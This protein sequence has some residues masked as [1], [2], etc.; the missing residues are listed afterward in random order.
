[1]NY[2]AAFRNL[3]IF[4]T[5]LKKKK[6]WKGHYFDFYIKIYFVHTKACIKHF[7]VYFRV[8]FLEMHVCKYWKS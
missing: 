6:K 1:M 7:Y 3:L 8:N 4:I 5:G 2:A